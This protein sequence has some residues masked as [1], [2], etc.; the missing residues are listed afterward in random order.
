MRSIRR[1]RKNLTRGGGCGCGSSQSGGRITM[2]S[3]YYGHD[4]GRYS[5][6]NIAAPLASAQ[7]AERASAWTIMSGGAKRRSHRRRSTANKG[8]KSS[9]KSTSK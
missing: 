4:S 2:A 9:R 6:E 1:T 7:V 3:E 8:R 5:A